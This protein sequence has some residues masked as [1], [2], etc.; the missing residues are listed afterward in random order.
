MKFVLG[1]ATL[2][3]SGVYP[4]ALDVAHSQGSRFDPTLLTQIETLIGRKDGVGDQQ[5]GPKPTQLTM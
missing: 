4:S 3:N 2:T 5:T 1:A